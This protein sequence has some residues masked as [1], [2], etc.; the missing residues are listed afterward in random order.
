MAIYKFAADGLG[1]I[2]QMVKFVC[3]V[4][5][6]HV[7]EVSS[8]VRSVSESFARI[9]VQLTCIHNVRNLLNSI[10]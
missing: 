1:E 5:M 6:I 2:A 3:F 7:L 9:P 4:Y 8:N 10:S